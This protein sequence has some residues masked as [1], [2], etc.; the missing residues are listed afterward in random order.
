[1]I[2]LVIKS[3]IETFNWVIEL[4]LDKHKRNE[5][6]M[7]HI[8]RNWGKGQASKSRHFQTPNLSH[9]MK[10]RHFQTYPDF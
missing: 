6:T 7:A 9:I 8:K 1:M 2:M 4:V 3:A 5:C 10:Y